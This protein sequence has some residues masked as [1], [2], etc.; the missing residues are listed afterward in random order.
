MR[1]ALSAKTLRDTTGRDRRR[2]DAYME[3]VSAGLESVAP[4]RHNNALKHAAW[5]LGCLTAA[6]AL[7]HGDVEDALYVAVL[8]NGLVHDDGEQ[9]TWAIIRSGLGAGPQEAIDLDADDQP[10]ARRRRQKG[11]QP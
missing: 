6:G 3:K 9:Q 8:H 2:G 10:P 11:Q 4:G 5:T 7:E 1:W